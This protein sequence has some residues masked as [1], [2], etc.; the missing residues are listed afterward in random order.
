MDRVEAEAIDDSGREACVVVLLDLAGRVE[1]HEDR[2]RRLEAAARQ[3]SR[4]S[5]APPSQDP[6]KTR[7]Q[8]QQQHPGEPSGDPEPL[9]IRNFANIRGPAAAAGALATPETAVEGS[10]EGVATGLRSV[11]TRSARSPTSSSAR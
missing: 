4:T 10:E 1:Q 9:A 5:L 11:L 7:A 3:N 6:P 2:L 8:R